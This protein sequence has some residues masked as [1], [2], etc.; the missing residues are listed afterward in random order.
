M[1][2]T[3]PTSAIAVHILENDLV[4]VFGEFKG[5]YTYTSTLGG[6]ITIPYVAAD[7][8]TEEIKEES[9]YPATRQDPAPIGATIRYDGSSYSNECVTDLT[10][11]NV[12]RGDAANE[13]VKDWNRFNDDDTSQLEYVIVYV[14]TDAISSEDDAQATID[15]WDFVFV[16]ESGV[17]YSSVSVSGKTPELTDLY[18]GASNEGVVVGLVKKDDHPRLVYLKDSDTPIWFDLNKRVPI[19]L[20]D[21]YVFTVLQ[22]GSK[23]DDVVKLQAALIELG[24]L[25]GAADGDY[26]NMTLAAVKAYQKALGL[27]ETGI[28]DEETQRYAL[29]YT[30]AENKAE[31]DAASAETAQNSAEETPAETP[32]NSTEEEEVIAEPDDAEAED[33]EVSETEASSEIVE[34]ESEEDTAEESTVSEYLFTAPTGNGYIVGEDIA[35]G[36]YRI[37][38]ADDYSMITVENDVNYYYGYE[39]LD[40]GTESMLTLVSGDSIDIMGSIEFWTYVESTS[41]ENDSLSLSAGLGYI[42]G[43]DIPAGTYSAIGHGSLVGV[44]TFDSFRGDMMDYFTVGEG[45]SIGKLKLTDGM[46]IDIISG[47]L[48]FEPY[49][50]LGM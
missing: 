11:T 19:T 7:S 2:V 29:T 18:P 26:G 27:E 10:I 33:S 23:G 41:G 39:N 44:Q 13:M 21:D 20:P 16:S 34:T 28:A 32:Q 1:Y 37:V 24:Y 36:V 17:E 14:R 9:E 5:L 8:I 49:T 45:E 22:K 12:I 48:D 25:D 31:A 30:T 35:E 4:T 40:K 15:E 50:G 46:Q 38:G 47:S 6:Q 43:K 42:V 3:C